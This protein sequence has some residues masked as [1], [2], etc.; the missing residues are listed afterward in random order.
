MAK[1]VTT[2]QASQ[3]PECD[4]CK[5]A[6]R[7]VPAG[8]DGATTFG[9]WAYMCVDCFVRYGRGLGLGRGQRLVLAAK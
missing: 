3:I 1:D 4:I 8:Y 5:G 2:A 7:T 6:G 9:P